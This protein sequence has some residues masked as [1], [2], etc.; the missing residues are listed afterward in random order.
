LAARSALS[1]ITR[2]AVLR[3]CPI[4]AQQ[5][6]RFCPAAAAAGRRVTAEE[7]AHLRIGRACRGPFSSRLAAAACSRAASM[8]RGSSGACW[9]SCLPSRTANNGSSP[10]ASIIG[11]GDIRCSRSASPSGVR[12]RTAPSCSLPR[13]RT[14]CWLC[15]MQ[16][17]CWQSPLVAQQDQ[18]ASRMG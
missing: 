13:G 11:A 5:G 16:N 17:K 1:S 12:A 9:L 15:K 7:N 18:R 2:S 4:L 3:A 14:R 6:V 8:W 10:V